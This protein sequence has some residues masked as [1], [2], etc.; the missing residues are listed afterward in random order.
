MPDFSNKVAI[1]LLIFLS[2]CCLAAPCLA[3]D[4]L[5]VWGSTSPGNVLTPGESATAVYSVSYDFESDDESLQLYTDLL[6]PKWTLS[7]LIDGVS[8][9]LP[10]YTGRYVSLSGFELYYDDSYSSVVKISLNGTAPEVSSTGNYTIIRATWYDYAGDTVDEEAVE[11]TIVN[12]SDIDGILE[13]RRSELASLKSYIDEKS[14]LGVDTG[15]AEKKY[16]A[17]SGAIEEAEESDSAAASILLSSAKTYIDESYSLIDVAWAEFSIEQA[18][19]TIDI[20][21]GMIS[22]YEDEGLSGDSRV[23][24][25]QS[26]IDNAETLLVLAKDKFSLDDYDS[27]RDYAEQSESKAEQGYD[28]AVSLNEDL[29][30]KSPTLAATATSTKSTKTSTSTATSTSTGTSDSSSGIDDLI[31]DLGGDSDLGGVDDIIHSEVDLDSA[32]KILS[33]IGDALMDAFDYLSSLLSMA[34]DN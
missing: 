28:Y 31:S 1:S 32:I 20:V 11:A 3:D 6:S 34:S 29:D 18:E 21:N 24:V 33:M 4:E 16:N 2:L 26:Y 22:E 25:I 7:I 10:S 13:T 17:A 8:H 14:G 15:S 23:W 12:P 19:S 5:E 27:A 9:N 30:L